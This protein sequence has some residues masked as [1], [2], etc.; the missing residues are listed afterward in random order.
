M[1]RLARKPTRLSGPK[2]DEV[3][4]DRDAVL[5]RGLGGGDEA[6]AGVQV[7]E[8]AVGQARL[9][10]PE[11]NLRQAGPGADQDREGAGRDLGVERAVV[12][13]LGRVELAGAVG[14]HAG[15]D[16]DAAGR[17]LGVRRGGEVGRQGQAFLELGDVDAA[18]L[19]HRAGAEVD[20]V[21]G[22][23]SSRS[24]TV[25]LGPGRKLARTR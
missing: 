14:D 10:L 22:E 5:D 12:A 6:L 19:Q 15:E 25:R 21:Q 9:A 20:L 4:A 1:W 3:D 16:V 23:A 18:G 13:G 7:Q 8:L 11:P 2:P 17:A 24:R